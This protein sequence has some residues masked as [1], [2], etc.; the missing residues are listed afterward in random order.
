MG[1]PHQRR[2]RPRDCTSGIRRQ[3]SKRQPAGNL[4]LR[5]ESEVRDHAARRPWAKARA[6]APTLD[7]SFSTKTAF[8]VG[9][10]RR[11]AHRSGYRQPRPWQVV[12]HP[13]VGN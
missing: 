7:A 8:P 13:M 4:E 12:D 11:A 5:L 10:P 2:Q 1:R 3:I 6:K 9:P